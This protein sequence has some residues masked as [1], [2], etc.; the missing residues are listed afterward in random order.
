ML[1]RTELESMTV[2]QL[3]R[4]T[5]ER[6]LRM[7]SN[8]RKLKKAELIEQLLETETET[9]TEKVTLE[10][11][12]EKYSTPKSEKVYE[13]VLKPDAYVVFVHYVEAKDGNIYKKL[14]TAKVVDVDR[15]F[16]LVTVETMLG[17]KLVLAYD[18]L[19][20]V[21]K[22][23]NGYY[24]SDIKDYLRKQ[25]TKKGEELVHEKVGSKYTARVNRKR[26]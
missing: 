1:K 22:E 24:P 10:S 7:S 12:V 4:L 14:R 20:F 18:D 9:E 6:G 5:K 21:R 15:E 13:Y 16:K 26:S 23:R 2:E 19:L 8:N 11:L 25:R 17:L 3:K